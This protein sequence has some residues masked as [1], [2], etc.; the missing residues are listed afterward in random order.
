MKFFVIFQ[1]Y[2]DNFKKKLIRAYVNIDL[3]YAVISFLHFFL[4]FFTDSFVFTIHYR[5]IPMLKYV[6]VKL[7]LMALLFVIWQIIGHAVRIYR[8]SLFVREYA[9]FTFIYF[10]IM[11][12]FLLAVIPGNIKDHTDFYYLSNTAALRDTM[13]FEPFIMEYF[14]IF[15]MMLFPCLSGIILGQ[16]VIISS[17][18]GYIMTRFSICLKSSKLAYFLYIPFLLLLVIQNNLFMDTC[19]IYSYLILLLVFLLFFMKACNE[20]ITRNNMASIALI[21]AL[22]GTLRAE[23]LLFL[24]LVPVIFIIINYHKI[25]IRQILF[26]SFVL[27]FAAIIMMPKYI[28]ISAQ[29]GKYEGVY[30]KLYIIDYSFKVLLKEAVKRND[31]EILSEFD[32]YE[33]VNFML[34]DST[35][36]GMFFY[37]NLP[38]KKREKFDII[39]EKLSKK[40]KMVY[41]A[42]KIKDSLFKSYNHAIY[43]IG[44]EKI[45]FGD[46]KGARQ[47]YNRIDEKLILYCNDMRNYFVDFFKKHSTSKG[48]L[49]FPLC[50]I[51]SVSLISALFMKKTLFLLS[52][53]ILIH[54]FSVSLLAPYGAFRYNFSLY[55]YGYLNFVIFIV[56]TIY[57]LRASDKFKFFI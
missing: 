6:A 17:I 49:I 27:L 5:Q 50:V 13:M 46:N 33:D 48:S 8:K 18:V 31:R 11:L 15:S 43:K 21:T 32:S 24:V 1:Y 28:D 55:M 42:Y 2:L 56:L 19:I 3:Y 54:S 7:A 37:V 23:G 45:N 52:A 20:K 30:K 34:A 44:I 41:V 22:L 38:E 26:F 36:I 14:R 53:L 57:N 51:L 35:K 4:T 39:C 12:I 16:I 9:K 47:A 10:D 29:E 40:Y 25:K